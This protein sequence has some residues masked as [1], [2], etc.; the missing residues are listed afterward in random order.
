MKNLVFHLVLWVTLLCQLPL[1]A[2]TREEVVAGAELLYRARIAE[3][4]SAFQLDTDPVFLARVKRISQIL[5]NQARHDYPAAEHYAWETHVTNAPDESA[6]CMAGGKLL[7]GSTYVTSLELNDAELAMLLSH[8][9]QHA[10]LEHNFKEFLE[11][12]RIAPEWRAASFLELQDALDHDDSLMAK[13]AGFN[14][15]QEIEADREG[16]LMAW[17]AGW[18]ALALAGYY[19]K[20]VRSDPKANFAYRDHPASAQRWQSAH[21]LA[22]ELS[23]NRQTEKGKQHD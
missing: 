6:S 22:L 17:R 23:N 12:L 11:A 18:P 1:H 3:A 14:R 10:A 16:L 2:V 8:E 19:K 9:I 4:E 15:E 13:L 5:I 7:V 21:Q 20:L